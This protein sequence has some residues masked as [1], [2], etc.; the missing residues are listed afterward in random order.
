MIPPLRAY[1]IPL[2]AGLILMAVAVRAR[3]DDLPPG[4]DCPT[5]KALVAYHG[6]SRALLWAPK[7]GYTLAQINAARRRL[8]VE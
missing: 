4:V 6:Q 1:I 7:Q 3:A 2:L 8:R 5:I